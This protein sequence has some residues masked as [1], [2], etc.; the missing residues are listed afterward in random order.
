MDHRRCR[1]KTF[2]PGGS[3]P[4][5]SKGCVTLF[6]GRNSTAGDPVSSNGRN[7]GRRLWLPQPGS[8]TAGASDLGFL[9]FVALAP[10][11]FNIPRPW[12]CGIG[13]NGCIY[14]GR[15]TDRGHCIGVLQSGRF[16]CCSTGI[17]YLRTQFLG[18]NLSGSF[19][20]REF[21]VLEW[22]VT[23]RGWT[24]ASLTHLLKI[25]AF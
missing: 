15:L 5:R 19:R 12:Y 8:P 23:A 3:D 25:R 14:S 13:Y 21:I 11:L 17:V 20:D 4:I 7:L 18:D 16:L 24:G 1:I 22:A 10:G 9:L 6:Q 2:R